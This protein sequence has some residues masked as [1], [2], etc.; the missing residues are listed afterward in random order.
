LDIRRFKKDDFMAY[1]DLLFL[2][3]TNEYSGMSKRDIA[4]MLELMDWDWIRVA[5][6]GKKPV[7]FITVRPEGGM[8][9]LIWL[10][11]HPDFRRKGIGSTLLEEVIKTGKSIGLGPVLCE[12]WDGNEKALAFYDKHGFRRYRWMVDYYKNGLSAWQLVKDI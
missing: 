6:D 9:H 4:R 8:V 7:G 12:V 11:V 2:T 3:S 10:D 1:V 5:V